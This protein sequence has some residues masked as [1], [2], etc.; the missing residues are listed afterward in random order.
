M[1]NKFLLI[2]LLALLNSYSQSVKVINSRLKVKDVPTSSLNDSLVTINSDGLLTYLPKTIINSK[3]SSVTGINNV[4]ID[5]SDPQNPVVEG[6]SGV[7][8]SGSSQTGGIILGIGDSQ[9][10]YNGTKIIVNDLEEEITIVSQNTLDIES[11]E[12]QL[13]GQINLNGESLLNKTN[14][15][16]DA[17]TGNHIINKNWFNAN[18]PSEGVQSVTGI[19]NVNVDNSDPANPV[20]EGISGI[21][22]SGSNQTGGVTL[23]IGDSQDDYNGTKIIVDDQGEEIIIAS[24]DGI[25]IEASEFNLSSSDIS[26]D[27]QTNLNGTSL[28][29]KTNSQI[30]AGT[31]KHVINKD[32]FNANIPNSVL[33]VTGNNGVNVNNNDPYNPIIN[34]IEGI[35]SNGSVNTGVYVGLGDA[36]ESYNGNF[37][38]VDDSS[39]EIIIQST[40]AINIEATEFNLNSGIMQLQGQIDLVG[41]S[42]LSRTNAQIDAGTDSHLINKRWFNANVPEGLPATFYEEGNFTPSLTDIGGGATYSYNVLYSNYVRVGNSV[43]VNIVLNGINTSGSPSGNLSITGLPFSDNDKLTALSV[44]QFSGS[45][46]NFYSCSAI[47]S[48]NDIIRISIQQN[49]DGNFNTPLN[50]V[51][52]SNGFIGISGT[53]QTDVYTP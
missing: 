15:Q 3:V 25:N 41:E 53:Y 19:N 13:G 16:I 37:I 44:S 33:S 28:L 51:T 27:G 39:E 14:A 24:P 10:N 12:I 42:I 6:I 7:Y 36:D 47:I 11:N 2:L 48:A 9:D 8:S 18:L 49:S 22:S 23:G 38:I 32:W 35:S 1:K 20:V 26:L 50:A 30:D 17:S 43:H 31:G 52:L 5:N 34:G 40:D 45:N 21:Y 46:V 4:N 29:N